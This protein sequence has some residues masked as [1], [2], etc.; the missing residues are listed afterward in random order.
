MEGTREVPRL[1]AGQAEKEWPAA[2]RKTPESEAPGLREE[3][4][5]RV[6]MAEH[7][8]SAMRKRREPA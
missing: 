7:D 3:H 4:D 8:A 6:P 2:E 5:G 1:T